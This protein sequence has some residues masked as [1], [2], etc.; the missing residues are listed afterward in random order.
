MCVFGEKLTQ[1]LLAAGNEIL[2]AGHREREIEREMQSHRQRGKGSLPL[3][4]R[5]TSACLFGVAFICLT[6]FYPCCV[7]V[8][9]CLFICLPCL[10]GCLALFS[11]LSCTLCPPVSA[12]ILHIN[13]YL[14]IYLIC[15]LRAFFFIDVSSSSSSCTCFS[16]GICAICNILICICELANTHTHTHAVTDTPTYTRRGKNTCDCDLH[17]FHAVISAHV[18]TR[19]SQG[20]RVL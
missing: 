7:C 20:R 6:L 12:L 1:T 5:S 4:T 15:F 2:Y 19:Y 18:Y 16:A 14:F 13:F 10:F 9:A 11:L 17:Y 3:H 8:P